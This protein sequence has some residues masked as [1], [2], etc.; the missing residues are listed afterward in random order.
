MEHQYFGHLLEISAIPYN[1]C[2]I[3]E[4]ALE[5]NN[6]YPALGG[7]Q[8]RTLGEEI[9][10]SKEHLARSNSLQI[11]SIAR[12]ASLLGNISKN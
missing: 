10:L 8:D 11:S 6:M 9:K 12:V 4:E 3:Q 1:N 2:P 5:G 7:S